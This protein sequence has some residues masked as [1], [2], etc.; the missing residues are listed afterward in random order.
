MQTSCDSACQAVA[1]RRAAAHRR[2]AATRVAAHHRAVVAAVRA[3]GV[4]AAEARAAA[5]RAVAAKAQVRKAPVG[6]PAGKALAAVRFSDGAPRARPRLVRPRHRRRLARM[7][8]HPHRPHSRNRAAVWRR[9]SVQ[10]VPRR[11]NARRPPHPRRRNPAAVCFRGP[12]RCVPS[13]RRLPH[14]DLAAVRSSAGAARDTRRS[15]T[16]RRSPS[17]P[18]RHHTSRKAS[19]APFPGKRSRPRRLRR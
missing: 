10:R 5:A 7:H 2:A 1:R 14:R 13:R 8:R 19:G 9:G 6:V 4:R 16:N 18:R 17:A 15:S 12:A 11:R 3:V